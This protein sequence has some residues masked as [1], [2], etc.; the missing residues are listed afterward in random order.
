MNQCHSI[1]SIKEKK[2]KSKLLKI[3]AYIESPNP[4]VLEIVSLL[5]IYSVE[6]QGG[7]R[8]WKLLAVLQERYKEN[9]WVSAVMEIIFVQEPDPE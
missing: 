7:N 9:G 4:T 3:I 5:G 8:L 6:S 2:N 1:N